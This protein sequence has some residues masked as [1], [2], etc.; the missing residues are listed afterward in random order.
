MKL[1][2]E[3]RLIIAG[4]ALANDEG[5]EWR[6]AEQS[7]GS[8]IGGFKANPEHSFVRDH[9][10]NRPCLCRQL[11]QETANIWLKVNDLHF[12]GGVDDAL[13][14][15]DLVDSLNR[16]I[17]DFL[18]FLSHTDAATHATLSF[19]IDGLAMPSQEAE[20][21]KLLRL[22]QDAPHLK[23]KVVDMSWHIYRHSPNK[24][25]YIAE[26][27]MEIGRGVTNLMN[28]MALT[29]LRRTWRIIPAHETPERVHMLEGH[30]SDADYALA[31]EYCYNGI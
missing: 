25:A 1:P 31:L 24:M 3:L 7:D 28:D 29:D 18:F 22:T 30:L 6:W 11:H 16:A 23:L 4:Y 17:D 12:N 10:P 9:W 13:G 5:L 21:L 2:T 15:E 14:R 19:S 27:F 8:R 26:E 20:M